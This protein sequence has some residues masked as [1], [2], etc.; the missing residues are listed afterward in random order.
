MAKRAL[1]V[2]LLALVVLGGA[3]VL[4]HGDGDPAHGAALYAE[5]C[6]ACHGPTGESRGTHKAFSTAIRYDTN[7]EAVVAQGVAGS[8]YM[9][10]WGQEYGGPLS[11]E[12]ILDLRAYAQTWQEGTPELLPVQ[13]D[14]AD[15][16]A[17][18]YATNCAGCHGSQGA[19]RSLPGFPPIGKYVDV[20]AVA[21]RGIPDSAMPPFAE[22]YGGPLSE[23]DLSAIAAYARTWEQPAPMVVAAANSPQGAGMLILLIGLGAIAVVAL[24]A[25]TAQP[26]D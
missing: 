19:G 20:L 24:W 2:A 18:L 23:A 9:F 3:V 21:R 22:A 6:L 14:S 4:A 25:L 17:R 12:D 10:A 26:I 11:A 13:D 15:P 8:R 16:G 1:I 7:F 5:N